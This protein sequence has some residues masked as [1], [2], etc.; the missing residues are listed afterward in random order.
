MTYIFG[1]WK[2]PRVVVYDNIMWGQQKE[3][4]T[5]DTDCAFSWIDCLSKVCILLRIGPAEI[6]RGGDQSP[7]IRELSQP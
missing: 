7:M 2:F 1:L 3:K 6:N 5:S 4:D